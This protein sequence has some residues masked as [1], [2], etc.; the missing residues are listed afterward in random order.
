MSK[1]ITTYCTDLIDRSGPQPLDVLAER[2]SAAGLTAARKPDTVV[3]SALGRAPGIIRLPDGRYD[4]VRRMLDGSVLTHRVRAATAGRQVLFA[5][6][7]LEP[8]GELLAAGP[9]PLVS[10]GEVRRSMGDLDGLVGP[11]GWLPDVPASSLLAL[12][13]SAG[14]LA[15]TPVEDGAEAM[16][17]RAA[18][19]LEVVSRHLGAKDERPAASWRHGY[20]EWPDYSRSLTGWRRIFS[21]ALLRAL[22]ECPDLLSEPVPPLDEVLRLPEISWSE[23]WAG[24]DR[25]HHGL[26]SPQRGVT[27]TLHGVPEGLRTALQQQAT[28]SRTPLG[29]FVVLQLAAAT[30]RWETP[31]RHDAEQAWLE[32][33][34]AD[35]RSAAMRRYDAVGYG[36]DEPPY[37]PDL[38]PPMD[39]PGADVVFMP[40]ARPAGPA[41]SSAP[42]SGRRPR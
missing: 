13:F 18:R 5:G 31:C 15:V 29:E 1:R 37:Y 40:A 2:V 8:F 22:A 34:R 6:P 19:L 39:D 42:H 26:S 16:D 28:S 23:V 25:M 36:E 21:Q 10:G 24:Q 12:R 11:P 4:A 33:F 32:R 35:E 3:K 17:R 27:L 7:E 20:D 38:E 30:Y 14:V 41:E 9:A